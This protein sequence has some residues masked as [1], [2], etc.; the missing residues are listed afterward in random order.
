MTNFQP[1]QEVN[2]QIHSYFKNYNWTYDIIL[3]EKLFHTSFWSKRA[4]EIRMW[5]SEVLRID[6]LRG[7]AIKPCLRA[8]CW[9]VMSRG[10]LTYTNALKT[11]NL[12]TWIVQT[13]RSNRAFNI[14]H[15]KQFLKLVH[16]QPPL[17]CIYIYSTKRK[18][19]VVGITRIP[20]FSSPATSISSSNF[21]EII[22]SQ[23]TVLYILRCFFFSK[24][25]Y[26]NRMEAETHLVILRPRQE[27]KNEPFSPN[28]IS[29][30]TYL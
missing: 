24:W 20:F 29:S 3:N 17:L 11:M 14:T 7:M 26:A 13:S 2:L 4:W 30:V 1:S 16:L 22:I 12:L 23:N 15:I 18:R 6:N 9:D 25:S 8:R 19:N 28:Q 27:K 5:I 10:V 21:S